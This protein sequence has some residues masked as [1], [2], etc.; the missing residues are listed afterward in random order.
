MF[1]PYLRRNVGI[2]FWGF[3]WNHFR[4]MDHCILVKFLSCVKSNN[5]PNSK[6]Y[7]VWMDCPNCSGFNLCC[8]TKLTFQSILLEKMVI[9]KWKSFYICPSKIFGPLRFY[10]YIF[11]LINSFDRIIGNSSVSLRVISMKR[12]QCCLYLFF[13]IRFQ[14]SLMV[15]KVKRDQRDFTLKSK[16]ISLLAHLTGWAMW[17]IAFTW[18]LL[19]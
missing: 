4:M 8:H 18:L 11:F 15:F 13:S 19:S 6:L 12:V 7:Q 9:L 5:D 14:I 10:I 2:E 3:D 17:A 1:L 16:K